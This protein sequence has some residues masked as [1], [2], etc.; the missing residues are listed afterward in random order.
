MDPRNYPSYEKPLNTDVL[1]QMMR[2]IFQGTP[3]QKGG[4][5]G[6]APSPSPAFLPSGGTTGIGALTAELARARQ[7]CTAGDFAACGRVAELQQEIAKQN[8]PGPDKTHRMSSDVGQAAPS[9]S[10][11]TPWEMAELEAQMRRHGPT[12]HVTVGNSGGGVAPLEGL[13]PRPGYGW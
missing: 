7:E 10:P 6:Q 11:M 1:T 3:V 8:N 9:N 13:K 4:G 12:Q 5:V 2:S